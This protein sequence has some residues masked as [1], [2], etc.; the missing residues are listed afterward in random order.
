M[1]RG[2]AAR[3]RHA[4]ATGDSFEY[5]GRGGAPTAATMAVGRMFDTAEDKEAEKD[6]DDEALESVSVVAEGE[7]AEAPT[8]IGASAAKSPATA[9]GASARDKQRT[10]LLL[11]HVAFTE[12]TPKRHSVSPNGWKPLPSTRTTVEPL[13]SPVLGLS[14]STTS[15]SW[16]A[17]RTALRLYCWPFIVTSTLTSD[18]IS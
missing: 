17:K 1:P 10:S 16:Y 14:F 3:L 11:T 8:G 2:H 13:M 12:A 18:A 9:R 4:I 5:R 6:P 7:A 15:G